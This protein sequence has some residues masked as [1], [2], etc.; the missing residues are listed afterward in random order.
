MNVLEKA[1]LIQELNQLIDGLEQRSLS[2]FEIARSKARIKDIFALCD[3]PIFKKQILQ[4]KSHSQPEK[5][6]TDFAAQTLFQL[7]FRGVFQQGKAL[8][9]ALYQHPDFGWAILHDPQLGWQIWLIPAA[10]RTALISEWENLDDAYHWMLQQ[11]QNYGCLKTDYELKQ[12]QNLIVP[13]LTSVLTE[14]EAE[15]NLT[16]AADELQ[17]IAEHEQSN[18]MDLSITELYSDQEP[19]ATETSA[20][21]SQQP[22]EIQQPSSAVEPDLPMA[23]STLAHTDIENT[24][25]PSSIIKDVAETLQLNQYVARIHSLPSE[26]ASLQQLYRLDI[27]SLPE[28]APYLD[29]L[30][31]GADLEKWQHYPIYLA[32]QINQQGCFVRYLALLSAENQTQ[33]M[34]FMPLLNN[35]EQYALAAIKT[36]PWIDLADHFN[37]IEALFDVY[38]HKAICIWHD[39]NYMPFIPAQ[40]IQT[41]KI[42]QLDESAADIKT[43]LLLLKERQKIRLIHGHKRLALSQN[44]SAY[45]YFLLERHHGI[46]WQM[47]QMITA[48]FSSP[49]NCREL[50]KEIQK[51]ISN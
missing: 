5:A 27:P 40:L 16:V 3:E 23:A 44:E 2:F 32:E 49:I 29:L 11:Q 43:P 20:Q 24:A 21:Q 14:T 1:K 18:L 13:K 30:L 15:T 31:H 10:N 17:T 4:F 50:Y 48:Q 45:P 35:A 37:S 46:S 36:I 19:I 7:S 33:A 22:A 42:I 28:I 6:A 39:E 25:A 26:E 41:Q 9:Q 47:I 38:T 34:Q 51:H 12:I 8:E